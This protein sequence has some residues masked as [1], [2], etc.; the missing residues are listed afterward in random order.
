MRLG[1]KVGPFYASTGTRRRRRGGNSAGQL[2][3]GILF[4]GAILVLPLGLAQNNHGGFYWWGW[5]LLP[6]WWLILLIAYGAY[7]N[8]KDGKRPSKRGA[9]RK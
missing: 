1:V 7:Q 2:L 5:L 8:A 3:F 6:P 9:A 4:I